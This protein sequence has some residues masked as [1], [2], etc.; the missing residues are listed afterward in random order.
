MKDAT[1]DGAREG[2][3]TEQTC[4]TSM[5]GDFYTLYSPLLTY[6]DMVNPTFGLYP[7]V[8]PYRVLNLNRLQSKRV[9]GLFQADEENRD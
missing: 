7:I 9:L 8:Y 4:P 2:M 6:V 5:I 3:Y 1:R